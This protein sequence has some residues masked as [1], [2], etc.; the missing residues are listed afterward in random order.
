M[1]TITV[2]KEDQILMSLVHYFVT[3]ESYSPI[4]VQGVKDEIWLEKLDGPYRVIRIN[5]N[6]IHNDEQLK[7]DQYKIKNILKQIKKKTLSF[8][9][10]ALNIN[11]NADYLESNNVI[12][13]I[14]TIKINE[15]SD[16]TKNELLLDV[17][18]NLKDNLIEENN[19]LDLILN[20][21]K[22]INEKTEREN[23]RFEKLFSPKICYCTYVTIALCIIGY[24]LTIYVSHRYGSWNYALHVLGATSKAYLKQGQIY[25][26]IT[27]AFLHADIIHLLTNMYALLII[28]AQVE[29][30]F[31]KIRYLIISLIS[32]VGGAL[33][34][35]ALSNG[36]S[37]GISGAIFGLLGALL[38]FGLRFR[39]Y[40][41]TS[42][43]N[44][45]IPVI[46]LNLFIGIIFTS[47]DTSCHIG[48][49]ICGY[50]A[51]MMVGIPEDDKKTDR[52]NGPILLI[53]F[54]LF[55][56]YLVFFR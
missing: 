30:R 51:A 20:V 23:K 39:L 46:I 10:N 42:L 35:A 41:K 5:S 47:I 43:V 36:A 7:F 1:D 38:Y 17:F 9:V 56:T 32:A 40:L 50:L 53:I 29:A 13:N 12:K 16:I 15:L 19:G 11:L 34:S 37:V 2:R 18:P 48:G 49:L 8:R 6:H 21:T 55:L 24:L 4:L 25:R 3:K 14:D 45:I 26:L 22:D 28:G 27:Y 52:I 31:G 33:L 44:Q 54:L